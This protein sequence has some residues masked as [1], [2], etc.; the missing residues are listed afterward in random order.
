M[1]WARRAGSRSGVGAARAIT[2]GLR[3]QRRSECAVKN[4]V[5]I[6]ISFIFFLGGM[7]LMGY[8]VDLT[9]WQAVTFVGGILCV[10]L[11]FFIPITAL[12]NSD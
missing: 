5:F 2:L 10:V 3:R 8:A 1:V 6:V 9:S 7:A 11:A 4:G 12:S